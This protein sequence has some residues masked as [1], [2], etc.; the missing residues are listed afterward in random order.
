M[1]SWVFVGGPVVLLLVVVGELLEKVCRYRE[2][3]SGKGVWKLHVWERIEGID[4]KKC[5]NCEEVA[6]LTEL[7]KIMDRELF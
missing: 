3:N 4:M 2:C 1:W 7:E 5:A 6:Q